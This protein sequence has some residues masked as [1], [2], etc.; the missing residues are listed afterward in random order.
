MNLSNQRLRLAC[1][2]GFLALLSLGLVGAKKIRPDGNLLRI[3]VLNVGQGDG[4]IIEGPRD[5]RGDRKIMIVDAGESSMQ[6]NEAK[7][8]V[9]PYLRKEVDDGKP[10]RPFIDIDYIIPTHYH[11]DH[12]GSPK[13]KEPTG[14]F[15]LWEALNIRVGKIL[16]TG[17]DYDA[18]GTGDRSYRTWV[19]EKGVDRETLA[20]DQQGPDRQIDLGEDVWVEVLAVGARVEGRCRV[21]KDRWISTTSQNDFST[22][23]V[24]HYKKFDFYI[25]GDLSGYLHESW[26][27]WYHS[28][29]AATFPHLRPV[30]VYRVNHHGSQWSSSY[31]F[32]QRIQPLASVISCGRGHHHPNEYTVRRLLG[33][34]DYWTGRP[35][36]SDVFQTKNDDGYVQ[37]EPDGHTG[38]VQRVSGGHV[39]IESDGESSF[40]VTL[41]G[42]EPFVYPLH[43]DPAFTEVPWSVKKA[44]ESSARR[45]GG[46]ADTDRRYGEVFDR[47]DAE[48]GKVAPPRRDDPEGGDD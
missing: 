22:V 10:N 17:L 25:A 11:R 31:A 47:E 33:F 30:E 6:G 13:G 9:E 19:E 39:V 35:L 27:A 14:I 40:T 42:R 12:M 8:V 38:K 20:F 23:L 18:A 3:H 15:Y 24:I 37:E 44:R 29:E 36:G 28:I 46:E 34:E 21:V 2:A 4:T 1:S 5:E 48:S 7:H 45:L 26:G 41:P 43:D 32:L 16:D